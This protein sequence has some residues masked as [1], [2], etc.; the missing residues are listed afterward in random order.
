MRPLGPMMIL[1]PSLLLLGCVDSRD[2]RLAEM[3]Q[4][5]MK[6]Q[7]RQNERTA[8]QSEQVARASRELVAADA[9]AREHPAQLIAIAG[10]K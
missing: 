8:M 5:T 6:E 1:I 7:T 4:E 9:K 2:Q 3:A 10:L